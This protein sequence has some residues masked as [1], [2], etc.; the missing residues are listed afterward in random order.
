MVT[1]KN[2]AEATNADTLRGDALIKLAEER[3]R[4]GFAPPPRIYQIEYRRRIDWSRFPTWA[5]P[6]DPEVF[7]GCCHEG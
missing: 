6:V 3:V 1:F 5:Q 4:Q 7:D 2:S